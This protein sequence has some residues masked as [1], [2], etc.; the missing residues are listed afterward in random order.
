MYFSNKRYIADLEKVYKNVLEIEQIRNKSILVT[1]VTGLIGGALIDVCLYLNETYDYGIKIYALG[2]NEER[3]RDRFQ[4]HIESGSLHIII[5]DVVTQFIF[6]KELDYIIHA[7]GDGFPA[8]FREHPV[9]TMTPAFIG[10]YNLLEI[11]KKSNVKRFL[12][13][14]SGEI[15]GKRVG[16]K[17]A[18]S[19]TE[20]GMIDSMKTRSC[21]PIA[22]KAAETLCISYSQEYGI[23]TVIARPGHIYGCAVSHNDNRATVQFL[24][25]ALKGE[26]V[27]LHSQGAQ[28]RS[29]TYI[30]DCVSALYTILLHG[31]NMEAYNIANSRSK[32][33]IL[34]FAKILSNIAGVEYEVNIPDEIQEKEHTPID[35]AVLDA[36]KLE[37]IGWRG[38]YGIVE[39]ITQM[40][41][42][43]KFDYKKD[44]I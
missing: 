36:S 13:V 28:I 19:E 34:E 2:R 16:K 7:A 10:T 5:Q 32:V 30:F 4:S 14:S 24:Q 12:Y 20:T 17:K 29:Y 39:G 8:A 43:A 23:D 35:Y 44:K 33:T 6:E 37:S 38:Q 11:A 40:Y 9:E 21:Y 25:N 27:V 26:K 18:F 31:R 3:M 22:K 15:Y 41:N 42:I 1:G